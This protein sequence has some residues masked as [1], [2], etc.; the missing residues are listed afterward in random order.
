MEKPNTDNS[1]DPPT[2]IEVTD[3]INSEVAGVEPLCHS[4]SATN[5]KVQIDSTVEPVH[6]LKEVADVADGKSS[7]PGASLGSVPPE[8]G[9][10]KHVADRP[11]RLGLFGL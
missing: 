2:T 3:L 11:V 6:I 10:Q 5:A 7:T 8:M 1:S 9:K 4:D